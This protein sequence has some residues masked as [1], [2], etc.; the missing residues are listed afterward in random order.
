MREYLTVLNQLLAGERV[1]FS[2]EEYRV[3][4]QAALPG[5]VAPPVL[6]AALGP[7]MLRLCGRLASGTIT[8]MGGLDYLSNIAV[9]TMSAAAETV[10]RPAPRFVAMV[11]VLLTADAA[12]GRETVNTAFQ[13]YGRIPSYRATL[14]RGGA[15]VP[16]DV[17]IVGPESE[18]ERGLRDFAAAGV[19]DLVAVIPMNA[20]AGDQ[21]RTRGF[22]ASRVGAPG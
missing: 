8:W 4:W 10:G 9:P 13:L 7:A 5:T 1:Q 17:A 21:E 18:I 20:E 22:L 15:E 3:N 6:V 12:A 2:G 16:A 14:D 19:T 11:P